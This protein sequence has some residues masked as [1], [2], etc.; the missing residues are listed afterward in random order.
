[1]LS[2]L[3]NKF[4]FKFYIYSCFT[5]I[6]LLIICITFG[7]LRITNHSNLNIFILVI[8]TFLANYYITN[9]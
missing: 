7:V 8:S 4:T 6:F 1:M 2:I 9:Y 3:F 5:T